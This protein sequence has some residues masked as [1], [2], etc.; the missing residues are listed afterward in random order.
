MSNVIG[1]FTFVFNGPES[2]RVIAGS[3]IQVQIA[4]V[5][6]IPVRVISGLRSAIQVQVVPGLGSTIQAQ[7]VP[8]VTIQVQVVP[9]VAIHPESV[10]G[11]IGN[12]DRV[13]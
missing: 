10:C 2:L 4:P 3:A 1:Y 13:L 5:V 11:Y 8:A 6:T 9:G 7:D 12:M